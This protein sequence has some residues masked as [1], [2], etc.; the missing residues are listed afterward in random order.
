[1]PPSLCP[2]GHIAHTRDLIHGGWSRATLAAAVASGDI[3]RLRRGV[4][5]CPH[6]DADLVQAALL[7]GRL[8]CLSV[9]RRHGVW[10]GHDT[11][12]HVELHRHS[13]VRN[14]QPGRVRLHYRAPRFAPDSPWI[15]CRSQALWEAIHCLDTENAL[16]AVESAIQTGFLSYGQVMRVVAYAPRRLEWGLRRLVVDSGSGNE[17]IVRLR[18]L[19]AGYRVVAQGRVPGLG[20]QDLVVED[21]IALEIDSRRWHD[22]ERIPE[23]DSRDL[24]S[25]GLGRHVLRISPRHIH[26][27]WPHTLAVI[28]R[29]VADARR[30]RDERRER[31]V[32]L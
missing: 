19:Q 21:C 11:R 20:R 30:A 4:Y 23:D 10:S 16:A 31:P 14:R 28:D 22:V 8:A 7:G 18:L 9:L 1:M 5:G 17:T 3:R 26:E 12:L 6:A 15:A 13:S 25:E 2:L 32:E 24:Q 29:T 27:T